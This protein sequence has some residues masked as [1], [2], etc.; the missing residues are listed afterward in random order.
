MS[1]LYVR[2]AQAAALFLAAPAVASAAER[3]MLTP[4][5]VFADAAP[6]QKFLVL[7]LLG[8]MIAAIAV[9]ARKMAQGPAIAGG[10]AF[11]SN[12]RSGGPLLGLLGATYSA[13]AG[14][15]GVVNFNPP[16]MR[17]IAP[18]VAESLFVLTLGVLAGCVAV[19]CH[20]AIES[21]LDKAVLKP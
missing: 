8:A 1:K 13:F 12:L 10:S 19:V 14:A 4:V 5:M 16:D 18:G 17:V 11:I 15:L 6:F 7:A 21:R 9:A 2:A 3:P 20:W